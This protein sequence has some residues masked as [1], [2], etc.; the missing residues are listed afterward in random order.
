M[1]DTPPGP[2][3]RQDDSHGELVFPDFTERH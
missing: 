3:F 2:D 1:V